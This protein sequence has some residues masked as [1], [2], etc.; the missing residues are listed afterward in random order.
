V[1]VFTSSIL[2]VFF[3]VLLVLHILLNKS[4]VYY[5][6]KML[7]YNDQIWSN[8]EKNGGWSKSPK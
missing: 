7:Q 4:H 3:V 1:F 2:F 8:S 6:P 5:I